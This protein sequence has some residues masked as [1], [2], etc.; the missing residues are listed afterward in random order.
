MSLVGVHTGQPWQWQ[1]NVNRQH[2]HVSIN[3]TGIDITQTLL[4]HDCVIVTTIITT[5][6]NESQWSSK[7]YSVTTTANQ[8]A[9]SIDLTFLVHFN[10]NTVTLTDLMWLIPSHTLVLKI[11]PTVT[12]T[13]WQE[14][15][16]SEWTANL[17]CTCVPEKAYSGINKVCPSE[18]IT[19]HQLHYVTVK[20]TAHP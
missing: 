16:C 1:R 17:S 14:V 4:W 11:T 5:A 12:G 6:H 15:G 10:I 13:Y 20:S 19:L 8:Y 3:M 18:H 2:T 7:K 9:I